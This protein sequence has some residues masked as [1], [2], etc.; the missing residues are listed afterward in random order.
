MLSPGNFNKTSVGYIIPFLTDE[1]VQPLIESAFDGKPNVDSEY[2]I[3]V[4]APRTDK[5]MVAQL[6]NYTIHGNRS[7]I[8]E[9]HSAT[10][11][12]AKVIIPMESCSEIKHDLSIM[13][14]RQS[15][16]FP[17]LSNLA[18]EISRLIVFDKNGKDI[19]A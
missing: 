17:D 4:I 19:D 12:L 2:T 8:E 3:A 6:G 9:H 5:R 15:S 7:A 14:I 16:L 1:R 13:G 11:Y 18:Q 10:K